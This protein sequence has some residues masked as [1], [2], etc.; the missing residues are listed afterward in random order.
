L[1]EDPGI[2]I[3]VFVYEIHPAKTF[4]GSSLPK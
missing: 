2:K 1:D 4:P 3:G